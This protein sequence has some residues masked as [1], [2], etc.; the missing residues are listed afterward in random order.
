MA[1][2]SSSLPKPVKYLVIPDVHNRFEWAEA[3]I[4]IVGRKID[5]V[6]F[7]GD[8]FDSY[9]DN[10]SMAQAT[11]EWLRFSIHLGRIHL[12]G[13]HDIP[14]RWS[15]RVC[16]CPGYTKGKHRAIAGGGGP[17]RQVDWELIRLELIIRPRCPSV[18]P[19]VLSHAGFTL[20]NLYGV[21]DLHDVTRRGRCSHLRNY[22]VE[23]RLEHISNTSKRCLATA[24][25]G[26]SHFWMRR[27]DRVGDRTIGGPFWIDRQQFLFPLPG[28]DQVVGHTATLTPGHHCMPHKKSPTAEV[29]FIDGGGRYAAVI[30]TAEITPRGGFLVTP[31]HA[32][33]EKIGEPWAV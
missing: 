32:C 19:L 30:D 12:M 11:A 7:L 15:S 3:L 1:L 33:G 28:I 17:M 25:A 27:G 2:G 4:A 5:Q 23:E 18:R 29:W 24:R 9:N 6:V 10:E 20:A 14:Y 8:Y 26:E 22:L 13:N 16:P 31:I 21:E